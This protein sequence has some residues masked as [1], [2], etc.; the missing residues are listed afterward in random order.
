LAF[1]VIV[2]IAAGS[3][4]YPTPALA[5]TDPL[6][7]TYTIFVPLYREANMVPR[8][9][10]SIERLQYPTHKLQVLLLLEQDDEETLA[11]TC[12]MELPPHFETVV[13]PPGGPR[14][15]PNALDFG[16]ARATGMYCVIYDAEDRP[17]PDQLLKAV[18]GFRDATPE[19]ACLQARLAFWN[20]T[21][22]L[23]TRF[24]WAE[25]VVH[26]EWVLTG[27]AKLRLVPPLGGT[28][29]H[30]I[31]AC[32]RKVAI[33]QEALPF[34][35][36]YAGAWDPYNVTEDADLAAALAAQG[37]RIAMLDSTTFEEATSRARYADRQR[38]RWLKGYAQTGLVY[39]RRPWQ[40]AKAMGVGKWFCF[41]LL[42][43]GTP[44][45][46]LLAPIFWA[47][48]IAYLATRSPGIEALF[49]GP[50][51][52]AGVLL[53][54][55]GNLAIF[56]QMTI[57]C[58]KRGSFGSVK[59]MLLLPVWWLFTCWSAYAAAFELAFRTH[60][61]HKTAHGHDL[62]KEESTASPPYQ[63]AARPTRKGIAA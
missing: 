31:T 26:F 47:V 63:E 59:F 11:T 33:P 15:K 42:M 55:A 36:H 54:V 41:V 34:D 10:E 46:L 20:T 4:E 52:Y 24:Y 28:S 19:V 40:Y 38:R 12:G 23:I 2:W 17:E 45:S 57:A 30:F 13:I 58:L 44:A 35:H 37:Y 1:R 39:T 21:S 6:L 32:L 61:W 50:V 7:P 51:Y 60:H 62:E 27:I 43:L 14:T 53:L 18:A 8:L 16:L 25:Y 56:Y 22:S 3:F 29:N 9:V 48:T 49:P 5:P